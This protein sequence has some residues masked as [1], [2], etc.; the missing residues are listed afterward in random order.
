MADRKKW[1][2]IFRHAKAHSGF[3]VPMDEE[4][5]DQLLVYAYGILLGEDM[6][7]V[8]KNIE[9]VLVLMWKF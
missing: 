1:K 7:S 4:E 6:L 5:E 8:N 3:V 2:D 9:S